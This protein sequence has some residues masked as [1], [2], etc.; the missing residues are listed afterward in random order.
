MNSPLTK[1][2]WWERPSLPMLPATMA[3]GSLRTS[4]LT[5]QCIREGHTRESKYF[6]GSSKAAVML[7]GYLKGDGSVG[8]EGLAPLILH[9]TRAAMGFQSL[10][11]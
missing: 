7:L 5:S 10:T 11:A 2:T 3:P 9:H 1:S 4:P 8:Q 6:R